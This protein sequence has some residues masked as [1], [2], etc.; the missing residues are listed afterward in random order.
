MFFN[1]HAPPHFHAFVETDEAKIS[2]ATGDLIGGRLPRT[3][4]RL[5]KECVLENQAALMQNWERARRS[6]PL[7]RISDHANDD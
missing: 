2:I 4:Q 1:D 7:E 6:E 3:A 5:V